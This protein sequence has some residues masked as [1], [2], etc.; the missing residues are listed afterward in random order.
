MR[1]CW[2]SYAKEGDVNK[3]DLCGKDTCTTHTAEQRAGWAAWKHIR[4][5]QNRQRP[6]CK[7]EDFPGDAV[8]GRK[9]AQVQWGASHWHWERTGLAV[10]TSQVT[11]DWRQGNQQ[12]CSSYLGNKSEN[13]EVANTRDWAIS[14]SPPL[15]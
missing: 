11:K 5:H 3:P 13:R 2:Q 12:R 4:K 6:A 15:C 10:T 1:G 14:Q 9:P 8:A 7:K